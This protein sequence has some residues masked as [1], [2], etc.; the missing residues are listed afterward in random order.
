[1][2]VREP[3]PRRTGAT[4]RLVA[5]SRFTLS[6]SF[7][8]SLSLSLFLSFSL[9]QAP[10]LVSPELRASIC[11][12]VLV[13]LLA[14]VRLSRVREFADKFRATSVGAVS[15]S[16]CALAPNG[17]ARVVRYVWMYMCV[18]CICVSARVFRER[19]EGNRQERKMF[20][21]YFRGARK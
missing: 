19:R 9:L 20:T 14:L 1:M 5:A 7:S 13:R 11:I 21:A 10:S 2:R 3:G 12:G 4:Q 17:A 15:S 8:L 16:L 6:P 18:S